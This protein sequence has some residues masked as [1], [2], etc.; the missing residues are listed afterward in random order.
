[1]AA[2]NQ[3]I[4]GFFKRPPVAFPLVALFHAFL[5]I[6]A[7]YDFRS[8]P[9]SD[10]VWI[11]VLWHAAYLAAAI[12]LVGLKRWGA[13]LYLAITSANIILRFVLRNPSDISAYTDAVFPL[14][15]VFCFLI[16]FFYR[17]FS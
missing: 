15:I 10:P 11:Q 8:I 12:A 16:L 13:W 14:D 2:L 3:S 9:V 1:M 7:V 5:L 6:R 4:I 17:R